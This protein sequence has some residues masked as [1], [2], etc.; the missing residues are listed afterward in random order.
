ML[1]FLNWTLNQIVQIL[2][3]FRKYSTVSER[4]RF[5]II[6][7]FVFMFFTNC[8]LTLLV[9]GEVGNV[10]IRNILSHIFLT[11]NMKQIVVYK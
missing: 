5:S 6:C 7:L 4:N 10:S 8:I 3:R 2:I 11:D 1:I 9:Q